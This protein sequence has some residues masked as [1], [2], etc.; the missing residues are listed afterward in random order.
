MDR[1]KS[2]EHACDRL[3]ADGHHD[4][5]AHRGI[6]RVDLRRLEVL[7]RVNRELGTT[8][9]VITH[10]AAIAGMANRVARMADGGIVEIRR[11]ETPQSPAELDW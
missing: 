6:E 11:N 7:D 3:V 8:T 4:R 10:A 1:A 2:R 5:R 9:A